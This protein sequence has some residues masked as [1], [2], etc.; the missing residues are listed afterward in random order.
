MIVNF[1]KGQIMNKSQTLYI[2]LEGDFD[3]PPNI[4]VKIAPEMPLPQ[5]RDRY[6]NTQ[7]SHLIMHVYAATD[8]SGNTFEVAVQPLQTPAPQ[9]I[10]PTT[11]AGTPLNKI[12][13]IGPS[14]MAKLHEAGIESIEDLRQAGTTTA[15]RAALARQVDRPESMVLRWVQLADLM[16]I[17]GVNAEQSALLWEAGIKTPADLPAQP[18][19][20]L[21]PI[22]RKTN[23]EKSVVKKLPSNSQLAAWI[24]Q[25]KKLPVLLE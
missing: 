2:W 14:F 4:E 16:R 19:D 22:L 24:E 10:S 6:V 12:K 1:R 13:G 25:A 8:D 18:A 15:K 23:E 21:L 3:R 17:D 11:M 7:K 20:H 5:F 9:I